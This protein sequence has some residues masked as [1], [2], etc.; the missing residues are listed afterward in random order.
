MALNDQMFMNCSIKKWR[1]RMRQK[2]E[3]NNG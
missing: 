1:E 2:E 3:L